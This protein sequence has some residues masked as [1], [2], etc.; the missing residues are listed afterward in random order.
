[1]PVPTDE[2]SEDFARRVL[3]ET[4]VVLMPGSALGDGGEGYV[5]AALTVPEG[6]LREAGRRIGAIL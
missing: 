4:G 2:A 3:E 5:R 1:M 6:R